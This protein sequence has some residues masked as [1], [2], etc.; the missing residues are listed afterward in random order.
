M[1]NNVVLQLQ[2]NILCSKTRSQVPLAISSTFYLQARLFWGDTNGNVTILTFWK[3][4]P[5][6]PLGSHKSKRITLAQ[7]LSDVQYGEKNV[8]HVSI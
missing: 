1:Y 8:Y 3:C 4:L 7:L 6:R 2:T 5:G